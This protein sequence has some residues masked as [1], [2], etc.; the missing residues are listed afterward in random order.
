MGVAIFFVI[1]GFLLYRPFL[2]ASR[3]G[4]A[5]IRGY[6]RRRVLRIVPAYWVALTV[7]AARP[8]CAASSP[9]T[10]GSTTASSRTLSVD[11]LV[12]HRRRVVAGHRGV[13]LRRAAAVGA[14]HGA[15]PARAPGPTMMRV[16]AAALLAMLALP[17]SRSAHDA[18]AVHGTQAGRYPAARQPRLVRATGWASRSPRWSLAGRERASRVV[19]IISDQRGCRGRSRPSCC[20]LDATQ[21]G[22]AAPLPD[23]LYGAHGWL[24][25]SSSRSR[26]SSSRCPRPSATRAA[27]SAPD[28]RHPLLAWLGLVSYGIFLWHQPLIDQVINPAARPHPGVAV[29]QPADLL[30]AA[31][32]AIAAA[33]YYLVERPILALQ[34]PP[35]AAARSGAESRV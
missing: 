27:D 18:F 35:P 9:A 6:L 33:S 2:A 17:R 31:S 19:R 15:P 28:P 14:A 12:R 4:P 23:G 24:S 22:T 29:R 25:N 26:C 5:A 1:S 8:G 34:G 11:T 13:L 7:L 21:L 30:G 20:G 32:V 16:E 10:G 3:G